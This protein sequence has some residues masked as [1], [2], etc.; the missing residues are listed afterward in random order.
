MYLSLSEIELYLKMKL[1]FYKKLS[2]EKADA[3]GSS[4][5]E[6]GGGNLLDPQ[7]QDIL[8][9]GVCQKHFA[10]ADIVRFIQHKVGSCNKENFAGGAGGQCFAGGGAMETKEGAATLLSTPRYHQHK[11]AQHFGTYQRK[12]KSDAWKA[13][14]RLPAPGELCVDGAASSTPKRRASSPLTGSS[15]DEDGVKPIIKQEKIDTTSSSPEEGSCK[16]KPSNYVCSTCKARL[17]SAWRLV[18]HVQHAHGIKIYVECSPTANSKTTNI[19]SSGSSSSSTS[20]GCSSSGGGPPPQ[21]HNMRHHL[22]PPPE[23]HNPFGVGGLLSEQFRHH[24]L[25]LAAA[26]AA[27]AAGSVPPHPPAPPPHSGAGFPPSPAERGGG[28]AGGCRDRSTPNHQIEPQLDFYSQRLRQLAGENNQSG[29]VGVSRLPLAPEALTAVRE[30]LPQQQQPPPQQLQQPTAPPLTSM[31]AGSAPSSTPSSQP[32]TNNNT[33]SS[34]S[35]GSSSVAALH[36]NN[37]NSS[38]SS[39]PPST[40][41]EGKTTVTGHHRYS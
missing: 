8:T 1:F 39:R 29:G 22:L 7:H 24:G 26:A 3:D 11:T 5:S 37:N 36:N 9:C 12:E 21:P 10:L 14:P 16:R 27:V 15:L 31:G 23:L 13:S 4:S 20:S 30:P 28:L 34:S 41:P 2:G 32:N 38:G 33:S 35:T 25:N 6:G 17:H 18:Q 19:N 40:S